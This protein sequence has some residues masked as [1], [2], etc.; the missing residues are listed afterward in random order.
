MTGYLAG[1]REGRIEDADRS[2]WQG[3]G[4]RPIRWSTWYPVKAGLP[5]SEQ[6]VGNP[7]RPIFTNGPVARDAP[8]DESSQ[9][10]PLVLL[11]HGTGGS[12]LSLGWL[13]AGLARH[14]YIVIGANHHG[15]TSAEP[16]LPEGF[17]C[18]W[19]RMRDLSLLLDWAENDS[20]FSGR[21]D[22]EKVF[23]A[24]MSLGGYTVLGLAGAVTDMERFVAWATPRPGPT[25][26]REFP[27]LA[28]RLDDLKATS[29]P[30][31]ASMARQGDN[32]EDERIKAAFA[33]VPAPTVRGFTPESVAA[34]EIPVLILCGDADREAPAE[35]CA[36]WLGRQNPSFDV[37]ILTGNIGHYVFLSEATETGR[38][39]APD[40]CLDPPDVDRAVIHKTCVEKALR[41]FSG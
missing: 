29:K 32:Y 1:Y 6:L 7:D 15:N 39:D 21:F 9:Q 5:V 8:L 28:D 25:G 19:E 10:F 30:F 11:S 3:D 34:I 35:V 31:A 17:L 18:W 2:N 22:P 36:V 20:P 13:G 26:P 23:A 38:I 33:L 14:G 4:P 40:I 27:D 24:G 16:Y 12:A 37:E 41:L